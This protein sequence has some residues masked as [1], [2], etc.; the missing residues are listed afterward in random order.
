MINTTHFV[1]NFRG[2]TSF[3]KNKINET[4]LNTT[5]LAFGSE[6][7][8]SIY[9]NNETS[10]KITQALKANTINFNGKGSGMGGAQMQLPS[11]SPYD[12]NDIG[13]LLRII[14]GNETLVEDITTLMKPLKDFK[15]R[16]LVRTVKAIIQQPDRKPLVGALINKFGDNTSSNYCLSKDI[17]KVVEAYNP[18][19]KL[20][21]KVLNMAMGINKLHGADD[22]VELLKNSNE[23]NIDIMKKVVDKVKDDQTV[24]W[25]ELKL[26]ADQIITTPEK[27]PILDKLLEYLQPK[28]GNKTHCDI[29]GVLS[30]LEI[31]EPDNASQKELLNLFLDSNKGLWGHVIAQFLEMSTEKNAEIFKQALN[32]A[33]GN[34]MDAA[35]QIMATLKKNSIA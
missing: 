18:D 27:E 28:D 7:F 10:N 32:D 19:S 5:R 30:L 17:A 23:N 33:T 14:S 31:V 20:H 9:S 11:D 26:I 29:S 35:K 24:N 22:I 15:G 25:L 6:N 34:G 12:F 16:F 8:K 21:N 1:E 3:N 2:N 4:P 13:E